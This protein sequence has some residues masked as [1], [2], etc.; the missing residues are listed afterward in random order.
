MRPVWL[1]LYLV[2]WSILSYNLAIPFFNFVV[3]VYGHF[4]MVFWALGH[5]VQDSTAPCPGAWVVKGQSA[6]NQNFNAARE[7]I[8]FILSL[9]KLFFLFFGVGRGWVGGKQVGGFDYVATFLV[10]L[11]T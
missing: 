5:H 7:C 6:Y 2:V 3:T 4:V 1:V 8:R 9:P 10:H 11:L